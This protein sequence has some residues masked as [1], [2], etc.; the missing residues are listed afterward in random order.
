MK[1]S[2]F[3][4]LF[5]LIMMAV[6]VMAQEP[7]K[8][9]PLTFNEEGMAPMFPFKVEKGMP[10]NITNVQSWGQ[11]FAP[12]GKQGF[13][14][15][16]GADFFDATGRLYF[17]GTNLSGA[18]NFPKK[19][20]A[21]ALAK[22]LARFG[23]NVVRLHHMDTYEIWG[24]NFKKIR[25][26]DPDKIDKMDWLIS[27]LEKNGVYVNL[28]LHVGLTFNELD[29]VIPSK[30]YPTY[31]KGIDNIDPA[32]LQ[33]QK[34]YAKAFLGHVNPYTGKDYLN[35]P[36]IAMIEINNENSMIL[37]YCGG[38]FDKLL[39]HMNLYLQ[40]RWNDWLRKKYGTTKTLCEH[41]KCEFVPFEENLMPEGSFS[42]DHTADQLKKQWHLLI[43][44]SDVSQT[45]EQNSDSKSGVMKFEVRRKGNA[46]WVPQILRSRFSFK[47]GEVYTFSCRAR[48]DQAATIHLQLGEN[49]ASWKSV[50]LDVSV[51]L[52]DQ[53]KTCE[54]SFTASKDEPNVR[55]MIGNFTAGN[56]YYFSDF[57][58]RKGGQIGITKAQ[59]LEEGSVEILKTRLVPSYGYTEAQKADWV[60]FL[61]DVEETYWLAMYHYVKDELKAKPPISGTQLRYGFWY[62]Q[63][64]LDYCDIHAYWNHPSFPRKRWDYNDWEIGSAALSSEILSSRATLPGL[65]SARVL[66]RPLTVS[67][68]NHPY[69]NFYSAE[70]IPMLSA[71]GAFQNW[72]GIYQYTW[73]HQPKYDPDFTDKRFFDAC[74]SQGT[75]VHLPASYALFVRGDV[76]RGSSRFEYSASM[77]EQKEL[78]L[79]PEML[80]GYHRELKLLND[81]ALTL[82]VPSG[83]YLTD[84][85][86]SKK[87]ANVK[88]IESW[89]DLP[90]TCGSPDRN[91]IRSDTGELLWNFEK[92]RAW[93]QTDTAGTRLFSGFVRDRSFE[94]D[95]LTLIP[96]KTRLDWATISLVRT[97]LPKSE[98]LQK[99]GILP[100]GRYLLAASGLIHNTGARF[101]SLPNN[102]ISTV[103]GGN[104]GKAPFLCEGVP[105]ELK[106][107]K[108]DPARVQCYSLDGKGNR[109]QAVPVSGTAGGSTIKFGPEYK[110]LWYELILSAK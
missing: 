104:D 73:A 30:D 77:S 32:M 22:T 21:T 25:T 60:A 43:E 2:R 86:N 5:F 107:H 65:A 67:E 29:G 1:Y 78:E 64:K 8:G 16:Q 33:A 17:L 31:C 70:G 26:F 36:G 108:I 38:M 35:D 18:A 96:G 92:D 10:D 87:N 76:Q 61:K 55:L 51:D 14:H 81:R 95:G 37:E 93:F 4:F 50:G 57:S 54:Y 58:L 85:P 84:L 13:I 59:S 71:F 79:M 68:Y 89:S 82:A 19:E 105:M 90:E 91:W 3:A 83:I 49:H 74:A 100:S 97:D 102:R 39:P 48:S 34:K 66:D 27:E 20:D 106:L 28:N 52:N 41:W 24:K 94:F 7:P 53:W 42:K 23:V 101:V 11:P 46:P 75:L 47:K 44:G 103:L 62:A 88:R 99:C 15:V 12:A 6:F 110:T 63:G 109:N 40:K 9:T 56:M 45:F 80:N 72:N 98:K 69:P